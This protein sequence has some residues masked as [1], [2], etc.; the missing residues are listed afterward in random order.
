MDLIHN[1]HKNGVE[2]KYQVYLISDPRA[3]EALY[4]GKASC[5]MTR[6]GGHLV[7]T[8]HENK[9]LGKKLNELKELVL[10]PTLTIL[11]NTTGTKVDDREAYWIDTYLI[12][13][14]RLCNVALT[15][16]QRKSSYYHTTYKPTL[17]K[18]SKD[19]VGVERQFL[20]EDLIN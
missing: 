16:K 14:P 19:F 15:G 6:F 12:I 7:K 11:E 4:V 2:E 9:A 10:V 5:A 1:K 8:K 13:E 18:K 3:G 17:R 20:A